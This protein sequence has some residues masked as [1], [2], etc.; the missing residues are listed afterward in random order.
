MDLVP[1]FDSD[2]EWAV[3]TVNS[4]DDFELSRAVKD[5]GRPTG[6]YDVLSNTDT[7]KQSL[8]N[9]E[10]LFVQ[11]RDEH[12]D[13]LPVKVA[14]PSITDVEEEELAPSTSKGKRKA[15]P[16]DFSD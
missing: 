14:L 9:W 13:L 16:E 15:E 6:E 7:V 12:G 8:V 2:G 11:F 10:T 4:T 1:E 5:R 3:P